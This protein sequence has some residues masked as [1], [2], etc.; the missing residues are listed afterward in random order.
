VKLSTSLTAG[1]PVG[2]KKAILDVVMLT[3][4]KLEVVVEKNTFTGLVNENGW[5]LDTL[6]DIADGNTVAT[7]AVNGRP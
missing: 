4:D 3:V 5:R 6:T 1:T 2:L 7:L